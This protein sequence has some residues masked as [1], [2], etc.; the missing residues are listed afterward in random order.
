MG[1]SELVKPTSEKDNAHVWKKGPPGILD[2]LP[3]PCKYVSAAGFNCAYP[4]VSLHKLSIITVMTTHCTGSTF[5]ILITALAAQGTHSVFFFARVLPFPFTTRVK[6]FPI[7]ADG[8]TKADASERR[9][10]ER[11]ECETH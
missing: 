3:V 6:K 4:K 8:S 2:P 5:A 7:W 1:A 10:N 9:N 11:K